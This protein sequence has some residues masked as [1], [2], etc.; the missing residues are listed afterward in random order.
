[1]QRL[2]FIDGKFNLLSRIIR[3]NVTF[4]NF[5]KF[6][7]FISNAIN[8]ELESVAVPSVMCDC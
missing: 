6:C 3:I 1:M 8:L 7:A 4:L 2:S 5:V